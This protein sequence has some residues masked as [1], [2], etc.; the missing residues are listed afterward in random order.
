M[1][2]EQTCRLLE[3]QCSLGRIKG[4]GRQR[5]GGAEGGRR[6]RENGRGMRCLVETSLLIQYERRH[7]T[8]GNSSKEKAQQFTGEQEKEKCCRLAGE[9][10]HSRLFSAGLQR[11]R[12][13]GEP[14][15]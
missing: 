7:I 8:E 1:E 13:Y 4:P 15:V 2:G 10:T 6:G 14:S 12:L 9:T 3:K 11:K 5:G